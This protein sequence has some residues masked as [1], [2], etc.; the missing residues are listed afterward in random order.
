V[1]LVKEMTDLLTAQRAYSLNLRALQ[2]ADE[3]WSLANQMRR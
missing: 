3:M 2:M 1:E